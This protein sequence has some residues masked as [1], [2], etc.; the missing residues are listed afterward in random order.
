MKSGNGLESGQLGDL[1]DV[2]GDLQSLA[3]VHSCYLEKAAVNAF[4]RL[5]VEGWEFLYVDPPSVQVVAGVLR[6]RSKVAAAI[7]WAALLLGGTACQASSPDPQGSTVKAQSAEM[8][9]L[10]KDPDAAEAAVRK[11]LMGEAIV[12][13][14]ASGLKYT[15]AQFD[16]PTSFDDDNAQ[17]GD[18]LM[19]FDKCTD[20]D[21][22]AMTSAIR[23][24]GWSQGSI[25]H[26]INVRKGPLYLQGGKG[27]GGCRFRMTTVNISQYLPGIDDITRVPELDAFKAQP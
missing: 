24:N 20:A 18:L 5:E 14:K 13:L 9:D 26:G 7:A 22:Q 4:S 19:D 27:Y 15:D 2:V 11:M 25:S 3:D 10:P 8:P 21:E 16:V 17:S 12:L 23:A 6:Q 1:G